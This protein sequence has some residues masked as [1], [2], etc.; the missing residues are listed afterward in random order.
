MNIGITGTRFGGTDVQLGLLR[1]LLENFL[2]GDGKQEFHHGVCIGVDMEGHDIAIK[3]YKVI[4]HPGPSVDDIFNSRFASFAEMKKPKPHLTRNKVIVNSTDILIGVPNT[5]KPEL[6]AGGNAKGGTWSTIQYSLSKDNPTIILEPNGTV[7]SYN[8][9]QEVFDLVNLVC[10]E[11][12]A[13]GERRSPV[14]REWKVIGN[15]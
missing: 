12:S 10:I 4:G 13:S 6:Y 5:S 2:L 1:G 9:G 3:N 8:L 11:V 14:M 15:D 7:A